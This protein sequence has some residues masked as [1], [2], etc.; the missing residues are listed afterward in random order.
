MLWLIFDLF[1]YD[2]FLTIFGYFFDNFW[3]YFRKFLSLVLKNQ[4]MLCL[5]M[6]NFSAELCFYFL[7]KIRDLILP[8][9]LDFEFILWIW[10]QVNSN[11]VITMSVNIFFPETK[12]GLI[13]EL[14]YF[15]LRLWHIV[16]LSLML[17]CS[18]VG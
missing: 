17:H 5:P 9:F 4:F 16:L 1:L 12:V 14:V 7:L 8:N 10:C 13:K 3:I 6:T 15:I 2:F 11:L 18:Q